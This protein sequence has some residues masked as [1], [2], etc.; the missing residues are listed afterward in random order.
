MAQ[1]NRAELTAIR[2]LAKGEKIAAGPP[3]HGTPNQF[4]AGWAAAYGSN[5]RAARK[6]V[7]DFLG[8]QLNVSFWSHADAEELGTGSHCAIHYGGQD[9]LL[10]FALRE[11]DQEV[12]DKVIQVEI[13]CMAIETLAST[14][15]GHVVLAGARCW[16]GGD[17]DQRKIR[18]RRRAYLFGKGGHMPA[19][20]GTA[21]DWTGLWVLVQLDAAAAR[22]ESWAKPWPDIRHQIAGAG[23]EHLPPSRNGLVIERNEIGFRT[24]FEAGCVG[25][26]HPAY[27]SLWS[28]HGGQEVYGCHPNGAKNEPGGPNMPADLPLPDLPDGSGQM[29]RYALPGA[30][31]LARGSA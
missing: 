23:Q 7:M 6:G 17:A 15:S 28:D 4:F 25:M 12:L 14:P 21:L 18:D 10:L 13:A 3:Q 29:V 9:G 1:T 2:S 16:I 20:L 24:Y 22:G 26:L 19:T 30:G 5:P 31:S 11:G 27:W 8:W